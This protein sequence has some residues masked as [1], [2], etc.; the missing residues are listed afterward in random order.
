MNRES[1]TLDTDPPASPPS[2]EDSDPGAAQGPERT[3]G[4]PT[5]RPG[6]RGLGVAGK[7]YLGLGGAFALALAASLVGGYSFLNVGDAQRRITERS[8]PDLNSA[9]LLAQRGALIVAATPR[10]ISS[11]TREELADARAE[12]EAH[13]SGFG[14]IVA[15]V[16]RMEV[17]QGL[18]DKMDEVASSLIENIDW[19]DRSVEKRIEI[20]A[21]RNRMAEE[22]QIERRAVGDI[23]VP[24]IDDQILFLA[25]GYRTLEDA[26]ADHEERASYEELSHYRSLLTLRAQ[27]SLAES[28]LGQALQVADAALIRPIRERFDAVARNLERVRE[29]VD[30]PELETHLAQ[31]VGFGTKGNSAFR[32]REN[33]IR[34]VA[35]QQEY[36]ARNRRLETELVAAAEEIVEAARMHAAAAAADSESAIQLG[37][38]LLLTLNVIGIVALVLIGWLLVGR[39]LV[40]RITSLAASMR[41]MAAGDLETSVDVGGRDEVTD[42][43]DALEVFRQHA[44]EVQRLNL[45][46]MLAEEVR[47]KNVELEGVLSDLR[48]AQNQVVLQEKL[49][50]LGQLTAGVAH[51]IKNPLNFIKNFSEVSRELTEELKEILDEGGGK[52][53]ENTRSELDDVTEEL[54]TSLG[55]IVEHSLRADSIVRGMLSHSRDSSGDLE[56]VDVNAMLMEYANLAYHSRRALD[57]EFNVTFHQEFDEGAGEI[58]AVP[59]DMSRVFLNLVTNACQATD[60]RRKGESGEYHPTLWLKTTR[61]DEMVS[62]RVRDNGTGIPEDV[63]AKIFEPFF[64]TKATNEG[65][66]LGLSISNDI[67]QRHGGQMSVE[68]KE[69]EFTEFIVRLPVVGAATAVIQ[70]PEEGGEEDAAA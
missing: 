60:E 30:L 35:L 45:V 38:I 10:L 31:L 17:R 48:R 29:K 50:A 6:R 67:V 40:R 27:S 18:I 52:L 46:E 41:R 32:L 14:E 59:Q 34:L 39:V 70:E 44:L 42:M 26:P 63:K 16:R 3:D 24:K 21:D 2:G 57:S 64:T 20:A 25:T 56:P 22:I 54:D 53:E 49:A 23:L 61:D 8:V 65:T 9:F 33:E 58:H 37:L 36:L 15:S 55:K 1:D 7:L 51:E 47:A 19:I 68:S 69:G 4:A 11:D 66:G 43:A 5:T 62:V 12:F 28:L 13:R